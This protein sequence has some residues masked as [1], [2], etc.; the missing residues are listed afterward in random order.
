MNLF[1]AL[2]PLIAFYLAESW[3]GLQA[4]VLTAMGFSAVHLVWEWLQK[5]RL[6]KLVLFSAALVCG[7]GGLSLLS[8]DERFV[9]WTPVIA[10][11]V[12]A[13]VVFA[14]LFF[15]PPLHVAALREADP[16]LELDDDALRV[17]RGLVVRFGMVL[18][19]HAALTAWATTQ[20]REIW[21]LVSGPVQYAV[22]GLQFV[23]EFLW[24]R[25]VTSSAHV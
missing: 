16:E 6:N 21:V 4:G 8:S 13:G 24:S 18:V 3:Y 1:F 10:D 22:F 9:L 2:I 7:L 17:L 11:G 23:G 12:F 5:R 15:D 20:P 19:L 14:G 25:F